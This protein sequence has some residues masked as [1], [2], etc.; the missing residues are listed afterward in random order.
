M[1]EKNGRLLNWAWI[2]KI[3]WAFSIEPKPNFNFPF[4]CMV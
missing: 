4:L 1:T 3:D 2:Y